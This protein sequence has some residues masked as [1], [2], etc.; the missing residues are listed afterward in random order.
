MRRMRDLIRLPVIGQNT[1]EKLG[2]VKDILF[3][4]KASVVTGIIMEKESL[5]KQQQRKIARADILSFGKESL[6]I[7][8]ITRKKCVGTCWSEK[9]GTKVFDGD[10]EIKGTVGDVFVDN[11]VESVLGYE[12]SDGLLADLLKGREAIFEENI[13]AESRDVIVIEGGSET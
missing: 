10:G 1:G 2:W 13:L 12:I 9:V 11:L 3:D 5:L 8:K 6:L 4:E 7:D